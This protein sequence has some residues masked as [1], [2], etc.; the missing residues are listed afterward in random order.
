MLWLPNALL[1]TSIIICTYHSESRCPDPGAP[2]INLT[3]AI[4]SATATA[5]RCLYRYRR[6]YPPTQQ[7]Q[8]RLEVV[9]VQHSLASTGFTSR[10]T[11][12]ALPKQDPPTANTERWKLEKKTLL[13]NRTAGARADAML[14]DVLWLASGC[15]G[16]ASNLQG[17]Q[18]LQFRREARGP[19]YRPAG[20][21]AGA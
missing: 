3:P 11:L 12:S 6:S 9:K 2:L 5:S 4:A 1:A 18:D 14:C 21:S 8:T 10:A 17:K 7:P 19:A 20:R 13:H 15:A 16:T